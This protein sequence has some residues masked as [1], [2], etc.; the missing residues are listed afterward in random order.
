[1][2]IFSHVTSGIH[3]KNFDIV[4]LCFIAS[5]CQ[6]CVMRLVCGF[7]SV[8]FITLAF[9]PHRFLAAMWKGEPSVLASPSQYIASPQQEQGK[10]SDIEQQQPFRDCRYGN[11][12]PQKKGDTKPT[13]TSYNLDKVWSGAPTYVSENNSSSGML[14]ILTKSKQLSSKI[15][16]LKYIV[17]QFH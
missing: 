14:I 7:A 8:S 11:T 4:F 16:T 5:V 9:S 15:I 3:W 1:M 13:G 10:S 17:Q 2:S 6:C 12:L